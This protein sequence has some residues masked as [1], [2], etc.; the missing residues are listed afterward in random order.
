MDWTSWQER[1]DL[2]YTSGPIRVLVRDGR[3]LAKPQLVP[4][5]ENGSGRTTSTVCSRRGYRMEVVEEEDL[6]GAD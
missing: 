3:L 5:V 1:W 6:D 4:Y 2:A